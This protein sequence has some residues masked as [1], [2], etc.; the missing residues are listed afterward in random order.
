M[1]FTDIKWHL[2]THTMA[3]AR[4]Q[5]LSA[6]K[7]AIIKSIPLEIKFPLQSCPRLSL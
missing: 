2:E 6:A 4:G 5:P 7:Q 1:A 3:N